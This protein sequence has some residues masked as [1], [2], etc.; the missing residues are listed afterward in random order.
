MKGIGEMMDPRKGRH[1][2]YLF[3]GDPDFLNDVEVVRRFLEDLVE[4]IDMEAVDEP[5][6][7]Y[8]PPVPENMSLDCPNDAGGVTGVVVLS[9]SHASIHTF[10]ECSYAVCDVYSCKD[11]DPQIPSDVM[12][13]HFGIKTVFATDLSYSLKYPY[14]LPKPNQRN[15]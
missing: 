11:Y 8:L 5:K 13:A 3:T 4:A 15:G 14:P 9:T 2:K 12:S 7:Y 6:V 10:P 1:M